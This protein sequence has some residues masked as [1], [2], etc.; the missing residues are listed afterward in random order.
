MRIS[1]A[2]CTYNGARFLP[3]QL[4]S[5]LAQTRRPDELVV[6]DDASTDESAAIARAFA[7][8]A[9]FPTWVE[10]GPNN[11]GT[12]ANFSRAIGACGGDI[13][14]L[15]DQ[16]DWWLPHKLAAL[17]AAFAIRP[18]AGL[19]F[20]DADL[21]GPNLEPLGRTLWDGIGFGRRERERFGRGGA[22]AALLRRYRVTGATAAFR[23]AYR[24]LVLPIPAG[25]RHDAWV[26]LLIAA[27]APC[28]P[29]PESLI[30]YRQ[31]PGQQVGGTRPGWRARYREARGM[32]GADH[33]AEA[34]RYAAA[35]ER[36]TGAAGVPPT[37]LRMLDEKVAH[38]RRRAAMRA[39]GAWRAAAVLREAWRGNYGRYSHGW[40]AAVQDLFLG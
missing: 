6:C 25:W 17:E 32:G 39:A 10:V 7:A 21:V 24:D 20:S 23:A 16:D 2:V 36:L 11:R 5:I 26:A 38:W 15:A 34:A 14:V 3:E 37:Y 8:R 4:A 30:L 12:A 27:A 19:V 33:A 35:R 18:A 28:V 22:F 9:P 40:K 13:V 1:V 29:L 31:H